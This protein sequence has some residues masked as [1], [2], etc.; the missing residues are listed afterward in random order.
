M[1][2]E[3]LY[4]GYD[5]AFLGAGVHLPILSAAQQDDLVVTADFSNGVIPYIHYSLM[6]SKATKFPFFTATNIDGQLFKKAPRKDHWRKDPRVLQY[7]WGMELYGATDANFD[8]G[9]MT[10]REDVQWGDSL[11]TALKGADATFYYSNAVPQH[12]DLNRDVWRYLEDYVL[13]TET[14]KNGLKINVFTGPVL[15]RINPWFITPIGNLQIQ[16]PVL[17][18]KVIIF[19]KSGDEIY[20]VGFM[21]SQKKLLEEHGLIEQLESAT[22]DD[23]IF[24][25]FR[26]AA[27]YQVNVSLIEELTGLSIPAAREPYT[28]NRTVKLVLEDIDIDPD[29][30]SDSTEQQLGFRITNIVL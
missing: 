29:L 15:S 28:D 9:H 19:K 23:D 10:K 25:K 16:L 4:K 18:W 3:K 1:D 13:N 27:T 8:R 26:D 2:S 14:V 21:M 20:R 6:L 7:Q 17:F 5:P 24:M 30:E 11:G 12:K 22:M